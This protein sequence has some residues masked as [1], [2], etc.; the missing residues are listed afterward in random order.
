MDAYGVLLQPTAHMGIEM[1]SIA[2]NALYPSH[3]R[4]PRT[5]RFF[6]L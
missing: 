3:R 1:G 2:R 5:L 4:D 6:I